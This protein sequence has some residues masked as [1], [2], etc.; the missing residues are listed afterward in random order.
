MAKYYNLDVARWE[1]EGGAPGEPVAAMNPS[2][3]AHRTVALWKIVF[4]IVILTGSVLYA[5]QKRWI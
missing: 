5:R 4:S 2:Q 3:P 1:G